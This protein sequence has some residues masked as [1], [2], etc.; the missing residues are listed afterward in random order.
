MSIRLPNRRS[1]S[2]SFQRRQFLNQRFER[3]RLRS[4][5]MEQLEDRR[6]MATTPIAIANHSFENPA[7]ADDATGPMTDWV[8]AGGVF[9]PLAPGSQYAVAVPDGQQVAFSNGGLSQQ[10][11]VAAVPG[12]LYELRVTLGDRSD[13][14]F[15]GYTI[16]LKEG[17]NI[18]ATGTQANFAPP[19]GGFG[20]IVLYGYNATGTGALSVELVSTGVQTNFD[21]V[22]LNVIDLDATTTINATDGSDT[23]AVARLGA[24]TSIT[25]NTLPPVVIPTASLTNLIINGGAGD[26]V[27]TVNNTGGN[28]LPTGALTYNGGGNF[29]SLISTG[30]NFATGVSTP[31]NTTDGSIVYAGGTTGAA[32]IN[33]TGLAPITDSNV[34][35][36]FTVNGTAAAETITV[37]PNGAFTR[38]SAPTFELHD[39]QNKTTIVVAGLGGADTFN[40]ALTAASAALTGLTINGNTAIDT[41]NVTNTPVGVTTTINT[42]DAL[43]VINI[44]NTGV[45]GAPGNLTNVAGAVVVNG[46]AAGATLTVDGSGAAVVADYAITNN[47]VTRSVPAGFG[48]VTYATV[49]TLLLTVGAGA[50]I[51]SVNSASVPTT[52]N[53]NAGVDT[54][55]IGNGTLDNIAAAVTVNGGGDAGDTLNILDAADATAN[56]YGLNSTTV[57]RNA[58]PTITYAGITAVALNAGTLSDTINFTP[59][60]V[61]GINFTINGGTPTLPTLPGDVLNINAPAAGAVTDNAGVITIA[62]FQP[63]AYTSIETINLSANL[64][65]VTVNGTAGADTL[66]LE[67]SAAGTNSY[68]L[69]AGPVV[70]FSTTTAITFNGLAGADLARVNQTV[71]GLPAFGVAAPGAHTNTAMTASGRTPTIVG[72]NYVGGADADSLRYNFTSAQDVAYFSDV[73]AAANSGV[74]NVNGQFT[75]SFEG[76]APVIFAG[77]G[78]SLL[79]DASANAGLTTMNVSDDAGNTAGAGG[80]QVT[81]DNLF[82]TA[83]YRGFATVTVRSGDGADTINLTSLDAAS[84]ETTINLDTDN[85]GNTDAA[86]DTINVLSLPATITANLFGG[87]GGD[88]FNVGSDNT[89][90]DLLGQVNVSPAGDEAAP[91]DILNVNGSA[92]AA[93]KTVL[94]TLNTIE[95]ITGSAAVPDINYGL[96][97][98]IET[99]TVTTSNTGG[100]TFNI[101][102]TRTGSVY[103]VNTLGGTDTVNISSIA[104]TLTGAANLNAIDGQVNVDTGA[105]A[106]DVLNISD[107]GD[108]ALDTYVLDRVGTIGRLNFGDGAAVNDVTWAGANLELF[109][110]QTSNTAG[111][112]LIVNATTATVTSTIDSNGGNDSWTILGDDLSAGNVFD[113]DAGNDTLV[114]NIGQH[115]GQIAAFPVTSLSIAGGSNPVV[116]S[117]NRD[118]LQINDNNGAFARDL[119]YDFQNAA[120]GL[121]ITAQTAGNGL[122][123]GNGG[124]SLALQTT[125]LETVIFG[126]TGTNDAARVTGTSANDLLTVGLLNNTSS[127]T[128]F[129][130]GTP[131]LNTPPET[132]AGSLPG[133]AG[134]GTGPDLLINGMTPASGLRLFGDGAVAGGGDQAIVYASSENPLVTGGALN[135]FGFGPGVLIPGFGV[136]NAYDTISVNGALVPAPVGFTDVR[137]LNGALADIRVPVYVDNV[138][139][140]QATPPS[141]AQQAA[142]IVNG[143]DE[144]VAQ[145]NGISDNITAFV[146]PNFNIQVNGNLP[147]LIIGP[148]G[149]VGDQLNL[150]G[151]GDTNIFSDK[152]TPP[153]VTVTYSGN[154]GPFGITYSSIERLS[155]F[156]GNGV[157]NL[158]GDNNDPA[159][160]QNDNFEVIGR[161]IDGNSEGVNELTLEINGSAPIFINNV[162]FLNVFGD[163]QNPPPGTP[164]V[165]PNDI[166]TLEIT[167]YADDTPRGWGIDV[168]FN[169]GNPVGADG[170]QADLIILHTAL[171]GGQ[172]SE[173]IV[174]KPA[175][176]DNGEI[177][178][179]NGSFGTP[180]VDIDYVANTDIIVLD[181]DGFVNDTDTLTLLGTNPDALQTSGNETF[182]INS[183]A[184]QL[185]GGP[186][187]TVTDTATGA[188]LY[189]LRGFLDPTP[190]IPVFAPIATLNFEGLAGNDT[191]NITGP[192]TTSAALFGDVQVNVKGGAGNDSLNFNMNLNAK[193]SGTGFEY[194][195]GTGADILTVIGGA[196]FTV[197][198]TSTTYTPGAAVGAGQLTYADAALPPMVIDF[199]N[200]EPVVDLVVSPTL[201]VNANNAS[202]AINYGVG[203]VA[204][205]GL[206]SVD[207][208]ETIEF[209]NKTTLTINALGGS[210]TISLNN[211]NTPTALT[212]ITV[213]GGDPTTSD[214]VIVVGTTGVDTVAYTPTAFNAATVNITGLPTI[215]AN[216][217]E[218]VV[219]DA[220]EVAG[221]DQ[222]TV[223]GTIV[224]DVLSYEASIEFGGTLRSLLSPDFDFLRTGRVTFNG[225]G[226]FDVVDFVGSAG[227][228]TVTSTATAVSLTTPASLAI[229]T[230]GAGVDQL[231]LSTLSGNDNIDLDLN[232]LNLVKVIDAGT[233]NDIV[234]LLGVLDAGLAT[235]YAGEGDDSVVGSPNADLIYGGSG[236]DILIGAGSADTIYGEDGND[237]F[238]DVGLGNGAADDGGND[239]WFGGNGSDI[240]VW[241]PGDG[242]D[243]IEGGAN[244]SDQLVFLG[245][246][247]ANIFALNAVGT[248]T[249]LL[250]GGGAIDMDIA[251]VEEIDI[252]GLVGPDAFTVNDLY[253]TDVRTVTLDLGVEAGVP[254]SVTVNGRNVS[255]NVNITQTLANRASIT[256][257]RYDVRIDNPVTADNDILVFNGNEGND[258]IVANDNLIPFYAAANLR[259]NGGDGDDFISGHGTLSGGLG[260]DSLYGGVASQ[261]ISGGAGDDTIY[262][263]AGD[264][265]LNGDAG[266]DTFVG[267]LGLDTIDGGDDFDT[268]LVQGTSANDRIDLQQNARAALSFPLVY[269]VSNTLLGFD[270]IIGGAG[271]ET[272]TI[273]TTATATTVENVSI[274][275]GS[276]GDTIRVAHDDSYFNGPLFTMRI[277]VDGGSGPTD[278]RLSVRELGLGDTTIQRIGGVASSGSFSVGTNAPVIYTNVEFSTLD[279]VNTITGATGTDNAGRL[280]VLPY[281][282]REQ[283]GQL[284]N[285]TF[286]GNG[287]ADL[288]G[289]IDPGIDPDGAAVPPGFG[290]PGDEDWYRVVANATGT[291]DFQVY[292]RELAALAN[293]RAGLPGNGNLDIAVYDADGL[294]SGVPLAIA[295]LGTFGT[296]DGGAE[297]DTAPNANER[298]RIPAVQGQTYYLRIAG[299]TLTAD[300]TPNVSPAVNAYSLSVV[301]SAAPVA[302]DLELDDII[303]TSAVSAAPT[304]T[305]FTAPAA[306]LSAVPGF[307]VG[308]FVYFLGTPG[309]PSDL[310]GQ[311]AQ[312]L[313]YNGA[314]GFTFAAGSFTGAPAIGDLFQIESVDTGRSQFDN[315]TRDNTPTIFFRLDDAILLNDLPGN[316]AGQTNAPPPDQVIPITYQLNGSLNPSLQPAGGFTPGFRVAIFD[317]TD[318]HNPVLLG[319]ATPVNATGLYTFTFTTALSIGSHFITAKVEMIDPADTSPAANV[320]RATG[321]GAPSQSLE[322]VVDVTPPPVYFGLPTST[323]TGFE[324]TATDGLHPDSD[325]GVEGMPLTFTDGLTSDLTPRFYGT[326]EANSIVRLYVDNTNL[327]VYPGTIIGVLD[328]FDILIAQTVANPED[329]TNQLPGGWW[330]AESTVSFNDPQFFP[331]EDGLR[332]IFATAED[333]SG[334]VG[335]AVIAEIEELAIFID[336]VGPQVTDVRFNTVD[337]TYNVFDHKYESVA[338]NSIA[339]L[340]GLVGGGAY[341]PGVYQN[342]PLTGGA[343][344]NAFAN[345]TVGPGGNVTNVVLVGG[346]SGYVV[347]NVLSASNANLGG[348]GAGFSINVATVNAVTFNSGT[349]VPTPLVNSV[350]V[351][352]Q[353][354]P[355]RVANFVYQA[356]KTDTNLVNPVNGAIINGGVDDLPLGLVNVIGDYSGNMPIRRI[357][358]TAD[359]NPNTVPLDPFSL[360]DFARGYITIT[361]GSDPNG[362]PGDAD[363]TILTLPDDRFTLTLDDS[364]QDPVGNHLDGESQAIEPHDQPDFPSGDGIPGGDFVAR[365]TVDTRPE[366]GSWAA[367]SAWID[368]NGNQIFDQDNTDFTNRD[369]AFLLG[370]TSD[371]LFAGNFAATGAAAADGFDKLAAY[372]RVNGQW[373]WQIDTDNDGVPNIETVDPSG[374][375]GFPVAGNFG[376]NAGDEVGLFTGNTWYLDTDHDFQV[377][378]AGG[379]RVIA[380][381][382]SGYGFTGD[383]D[384]DGN[385]DLGTWTD[386]TF[387]LSLSS[388]SGGLVDGTIDSTFHFGFPGAGERP[389]AADMNMDGFDDI[390]LWTPDRSTQVEGIGSEWYWLMSGVVANDTP[391]GGPA[392]LGPSIPQRIVNDPLPVFPGQQLVKF[393]PVPFG[394]DLYMQFGDEFSLPIVGNFDPPATLT[395]VLPG[396]NRNNALDVNNDGRITAFDALEVINRL[397]TSAGPS[398]V[399]TKGFIRAPFLDVDQNLKVTAFDALQVINY[400]NQNPVGTLSGGEDVGGSGGDTSTNDDALLAILEE[401]DL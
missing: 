274:V 89:T 114:L 278:D 90:L 25:I 145:P 275:S 63:F 329:G 299:A 92:D 120:S 342:V 123:G 289:T 206:I 305:S 341:V 212:S 294:V 79:V 380:W 50:N 1:L 61:G 256:G 237:R 267:G 245:N 108:V 9:N 28:P 76:L 261:V 13:L 169:E 165:G 385:Y 16:N 221:L 291:L 268:I 400:L 344:L 131:Y 195:G 320:V 80:N 129:L 109:N 124:G 383:F 175:G 287:V 117:E 122:F 146:S 60:A 280:I 72:F 56:T 337:S 312:V 338:G 157:V 296:N 152:A 200:L 210:D 321:F 367:G 236:N 125:T 398:T 220:G 351:K 183:D 365:F 42:G 233:G 241:E 192:S 198:L 227:A 266:E 217:V 391:S 283:N 127:A 102:S 393:T 100:D 276:G 171:F 15:P 285:A 53:T 46:D 193:F 136:G 399:P 119:N 35:A 388:S 74:V 118:L 103:N 14:V 295:G 366:L 174:I 116:N 304:P 395:S 41:V 27:L 343:G 51:I 394:N 96:G 33:Y 44:G 389:V 248:R 141:P 211:P 39:L 347:G 139:F 12:K 279:P 328:P 281:D 218:H 99:I 143:G 144:A 336:T 95:G 75:T 58:T 184:S 177:I 362:I 17:A 8:S 264:D 30:G 326:A 325:T 178:V 269:E 88:T 11:L 83:F 369:I 69:N 284:T 297:L 48:G 2:R 107:F 182:Q 66:D 138:S 38:V 215:T 257:L 149:P 230:L 147:S 316:P 20:D 249:E 253:A 330:E 3:T 29:D 115:I 133:F 359:Q 396:T 164:S 185:L 84:T 263:G 244:E 226:G 382:V 332:T 37:A 286:L 207:D 353:D 270:G 188:I 179:T 378:D 386:D 199:V 140:V 339:T 311:R 293:G 216:T 238:G 331:V 255:D 235:I 309:N 10:T 36:T 208:H 324:F 172:V 387:Q 381:P 160:D 180:I 334:N 47:T 45:I 314:G 86:I 142:V 202:N 22:R 201:I 225:G 377:N 243:L 43:D 300:G 93:A 26:D 357:T 288:Q 306:G 64:G 224:N 355:A 214:K 374:I 6:V 197:P 73:V 49:S 356:I 354:L 363:D 105:G 110:L 327:A 246:G 301:N 247:G 23:I 364:I 156:A 82:E 203:S 19:D 151:P 87:A 153:N 113:A 219:Y 379:S 251:G 170:N 65:P 282:P 350:I 121:N 59:A 292:F 315:H 54:I 258:A 31:I 271:T 303:A 181:D 401:G 62:G 190:V 260:N 361:F 81:G 231:N 265:T 196:G 67:R 290:L 319:Y 154:V 21:N 254:D 158:I 371:E 71:S 228:D 234:N 7:V 189:R 259:I 98:Q 68:R 375:N 397:N 132:V 32:T 163:D 318:T 262:G 239:R 128:V 335:S 162:F 323:E 104:P 250:F 148:N 130:G 277:T 376:A 55:N 349:L 159:V 370:Y 18:I 273:V 176:P 112:T 97:D 213:N 346:G 70:N 161:D 57:T 205:N 333:L 229:I 85:L 223:N 240:F 310:N 150:T 302:R 186:L 340:A 222:L 358:F 307:Y 317:E 106:G 111:D 368:I 134:G 352:I 173:D 392:V 272:D 34:A 101:Q 373:R 52:V 313:T 91:G 384:G 167:P 94:L 348:A 194:D 242:S 204:T 5:R 40:V 298:V 78:G 308:K 372:G 166:D 390:G 137:V 155:L 191:F 209:S 77:A 168:S 252:R 187:V 322:I 126:S 345:I 232:V 135:I 24:N 360:P 4:L